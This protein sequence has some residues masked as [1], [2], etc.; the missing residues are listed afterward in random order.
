VSAPRVSRNAAGLRVTSTTC[1]LTPCQ[2][3][4]SSSKRLAFWRSAVAMWS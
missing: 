1:W 4:R 2:R 3:C